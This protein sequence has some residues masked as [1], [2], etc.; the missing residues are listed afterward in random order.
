MNQLITFLQNIPEYKALVQE[1]Q[2]DQSAAVTG[3]GVV[4]DETFGV[5]AAQTGI[6]FESLTVHTVLIAHIAGDVVEDVAGTFHTALDG[7][8][9]ECALKTVA[10]TAD[11]LLSAV[12]FDAV[13]AGKDHKVAVDVG[14]ASETAGGDEVASALD[15]VVPAVFIAA[16]HIVV[17]DDGSLTVTGDDRLRTRRMG[18]LPAVGS[19]ARIVEETAF[20]HHIAAAVEF[21]RTV[22]VDRRIIFPFRKICSVKVEPLDTFSA[23]S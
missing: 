11:V 16:D 5:F 19:A 7:D 21:D 13:I 15:G 6:G 17:A 12:K 1:L 8:A 18:E 4:E 2:K 14:I 20:Y 3:K 23:P 10:E 22:K 9:A